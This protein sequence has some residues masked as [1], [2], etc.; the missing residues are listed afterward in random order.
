VIGR[1]APRKW[2]LNTSRMPS[3]WTSYAAGPRLEVL[4]QLKNVHAR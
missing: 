2:R 4:L 3:L 1:N